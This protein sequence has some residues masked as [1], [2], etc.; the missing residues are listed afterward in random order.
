MITTE[1]RIRIE[2]TT[3]SRIKELDLDNLIFG[4]MFGDHMFEMDYKDGEW[5]NLVIRPYQDLLMSPASSVLH[6][7]QAIFEGMKAY[8]NVE[9]EV[10]LFR[11]EDNA[12]R[13]NSSARRLCMPEVPTDMFM[14]ALL[15]LMKL[16]Y[17]WVPNRAGFALYIRPFMIATDDYIGV[18]A[19][20]TYKFMIFTCPV[21]AYY[22]EPLRVKVEEYYSRACEGGIGRTKAAGNYAASLYPAAKA[23]KLGYHQLIWTDSKEHK[24]IEESGTMNVMFVV[25][26]I[27]HTP[28]TSGT[29]LPGITRDSVL[30][31]AQDWGME[32]QESSIHIE[33]L[34]TALKEGRVSEAFGTGTA[35]TIARISTIGYKDHDYELPAPSDNDFSIKVA[36]H[37]EGIKRSQVNDKFGWITK[38]DIDNDLSINCKS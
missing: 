16:D 6:Y 17:Q 12:K 14:E 19:S 37:L 13:L 5:S 36:K 33:E 8:R 31:I 1:G 22:G 38:I 4:R 21:G 35:A 27:L 15:T 24:Y 11:P 26:N 20:E 3:N 28:T 32:V 18:K 10:L 2:K 34:V 29:I 9:N 23:K 7:G 30:R 25:D